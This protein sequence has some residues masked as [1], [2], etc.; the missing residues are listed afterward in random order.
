MLIHINAILVREQ[1][2]RDQESQDIIA[3]ISP[4]NFARK[5][6]DFFSRRQEGTGN[7]FLDDPKFKRW[8]DER[9]ETLWCPGLRKIS[10]LK[11]KELI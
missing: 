10:L 4:L 6:I 8:L 9:G 11:Q 1:K 2:Y 7:W 3:W 5:Q